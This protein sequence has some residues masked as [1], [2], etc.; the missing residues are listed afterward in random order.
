MYDY[1]VRDKDEIRAK[2]ELLSE[3]LQF[4]ASF[5]S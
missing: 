5:A 4:S 2:L 1:Y 3:N